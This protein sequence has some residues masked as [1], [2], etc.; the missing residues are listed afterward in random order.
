M[1]K[2][3]AGPAASSAGSRHLSKEDSD[4]KRCAVLFVALGLLVSLATPVLAGHQMPV[5]TGQEWMNSSEQE[6]R[7]F[8]MGALTVIELE[9]E[10]AGQAETPDKG[11]EGHTPMVA[12]MSSG[13]VERLSPHTITEIMNAI[14]SYYRSNPGQIQRPVIEVMWFEL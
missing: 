11:Y 8:L 9:K 4:M 6:K 7:A 3:E 10:Y 2:R 12:S 13:W 14:D 5:V 1:D